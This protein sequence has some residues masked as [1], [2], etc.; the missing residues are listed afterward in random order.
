MSGYKTVLQMLSF[1]FFKNHR[2]I[3]IHR[4]T[5]EGQTNLNSGFLWERDS[6]FPYSL[7]V[8]VCF[9]NYILVLLLELNHDI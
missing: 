7:I 3:F 2:Y 6:V 9:F 1:V 8:L 4:Q 5:L